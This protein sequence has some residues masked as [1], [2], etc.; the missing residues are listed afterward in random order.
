MAD[1]AKAGQDK[2]AEDKAADQAKA[3]ADKRASREPDVPPEAKAHPLA[4][5]DGPKGFTEVVTDPHTQGSVELP[6]TPQDLEERAREGIPSVQEGA[7]KQVER[8]EIAEWTGGA[9]EPYVGHGDDQPGDQPD[10]MKGRRESKD[11]DK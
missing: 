6:K 7:P 11:K 9:G 4:D 10:P 5:P 1:N 2:P 3:A 8:D